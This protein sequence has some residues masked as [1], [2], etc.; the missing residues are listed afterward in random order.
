VVPGPVPPPEL[1][2][3]AAGT[4]RAF[5]LATG[6]FSLELA[7][8]SLVTHE[9][10]PVPRFNHVLLHPLSPGRQTAFFE[11]ALDHYFQRALR[12][13]FRVVGPIPR[14]VDE[15]LQGLAFRRR[16]EPYTLWWASPAHPTDTVGE[17]TV[18]EAGPEELDS[19]VGFWTD[20]PHREE[21]R[22]SLDVLS[23][24]PNPGER[25]VPLLAQRG[26]DLVGSAV[27][28]EQ[29]PVASLHGVASAPGARNRGV[30]TAMVT[31][32]LGLSEP[33]RVRA[34]VLGSDSP[35]AALPL[36]RAGFIWLREFVEYELPAWAQL[37]MP[38]P[39]PPQPPRWRPPRQPASP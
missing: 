4:D 15:T 28:L 26:N 7:G 20:G 1:A 29:P 37:T 12:P 17:I 36:G 11:K 3:L 39:G 32:A 33:K 2:E 35:R 34:V 16:A 13:T 19:V 24:H 25:L 31:Y 21:L 9:R 38:D 6:G 8:G 30:G 23:N 22:R 10:I 27:L 5:V 18:R 14:H